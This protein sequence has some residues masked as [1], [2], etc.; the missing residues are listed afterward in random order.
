MS[1]LT[2]IFGPAWREVRGP[3][4]ISVAV[5]VLWRDIATSN[6]LDQLE[7]YR[8]RREVASQ[9]AVDS[10]S[11]ESCLGEDPAVA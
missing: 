2:E 3:F 6:E 5:E 4:A 7:L 8:I 1:D 11:D 10:A 9:V